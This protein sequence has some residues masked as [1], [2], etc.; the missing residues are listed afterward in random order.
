ME[1]RPE[2]FTADYTGRPGERT[3]FLQ[4]RSETLTLTYQLE[5]GQVE[6][7]AEKLKELLLLIDA[8]DEI[9]AAT[10]QRDPRYSLSAPIEPEWRVGTIGLTYEEDGESVV[11]AL[12]PVSAGGVDDDDED[13]GPDVD[14]FAVRILLAREQARAFILHALAVVAEGRP[15]CQLCGLP[16][17][18]DGHRCPASNGH[19]L[20]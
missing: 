6:V 13:E 1:V 7:L 17:D 11:V 14:D 4:S 20:S 3:F 2:V 18:P 8:T 5:K 15:L 12:E 16:M 19:R 10:P 9:A